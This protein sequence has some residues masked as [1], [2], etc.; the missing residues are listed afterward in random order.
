MGRMLKWGPALTQT[1]RHRYWE[2]VPDAGGMQKCLRDQSDCTKP[3][4]GAESFSLFISGFFFF[5]VCL[6]VFYT[7][8]SISVS[9]ASSPKKKTLF[10]FYFAPSGDVTCKRLALAVH[11]HEYLVQISNLRSVSNPGMAAPKGGLGEI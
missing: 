2:A 7:L 4:R 3:P 9:P 11:V 1:Q 8:L 10:C 6:F 5:I